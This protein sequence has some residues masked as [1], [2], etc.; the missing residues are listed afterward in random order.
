MDQF[1]CMAN[2]SKVDPGTRSH[3]SWS[4]LQ[5]IVT[6]ESCKGL[7]LM[8]LQPI[9]F[10]NLQNMYLAKH[11]QMLDFTQ[12][13]VDTVFKDYMINNTYQ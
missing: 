12:K 9:V 10:W 11:I 13:T 3:L 2:F 6:K 7:H 5:Q 4:S 8:G 1:S